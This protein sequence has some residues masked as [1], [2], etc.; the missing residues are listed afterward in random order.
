MSEYAVVNPATGE[1]VSRYDSFTDAQVEEALAA[2]AAA[3]RRPS[4]PPGPSSPTTRSTPAVRGSATLPRNFA[5][6]SGSLDHM[7]AI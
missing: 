6:S 7:I 3:A 2:A 4:S 1:T 5:I